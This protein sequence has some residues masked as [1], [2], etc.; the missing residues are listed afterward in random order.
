ML[1]VLAPLYRLLE[2]GASTSSERAFS[3]AHGAELQTALAH[4]REFARTANES[5]LQFAWERFYGVLRHLAR[6]LQETRSLQLEQV[7][8][9]GSHPCV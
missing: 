5:Q 1:S 9:S 4:Y 6:E 3:S 2:Q 7:S 8:R